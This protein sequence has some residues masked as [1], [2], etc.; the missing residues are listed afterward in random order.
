MNCL[1][2]GF[3]VQVCGIV[4]VLLAG[5][6]CTELVEVCPHYKS[7]IIQVCTS[8]EVNKSIAGEVASFKGV[9]NIPRKEIVNRN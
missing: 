3:A 9:V 5:K 2:Q 4:L 8:L 1:Q 6:T 7:F